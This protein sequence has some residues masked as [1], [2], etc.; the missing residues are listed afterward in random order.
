MSIL[1]SKYTILWDN[2]TNKLPDLKTE[3]RQILKSEEARK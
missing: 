3:I 1:G 2:A